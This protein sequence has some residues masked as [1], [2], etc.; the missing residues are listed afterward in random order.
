MKIEICDKKYNGIS[1][2]EKYLRTLTLIKNY[3]PTEILQIVITLH[4][5]D[6]VVIDGYID[7]LYW[8]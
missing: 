8:G 4:E 7:C 5:M 2:M 1:L 6:P 3:F